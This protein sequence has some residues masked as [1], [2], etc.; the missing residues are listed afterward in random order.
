MS[1]SGLRLPRAYGCRG[2][3]A[4]GVVGGLGYRGRLLGDVARPRR[5]DAH[6]GPE[7]RRERDR[8]QVAALRGGGLS[9]DELLD[10]RGVVLEQRAGIELGLANR[11]VNDRLTVGAVLDLAGLRLADGAAD[12]L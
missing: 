2:S 12:V 11:H 9:A 3:W 10:Q 8:A 6:A 4:S 1:S 5:V 7:R